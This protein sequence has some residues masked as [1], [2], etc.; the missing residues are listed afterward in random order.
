MASGVLV[1]EGGRL[2]FLPE[3]SVLEEG[4]PRKVSAL[5]TVLR[6]RHS[7]PGLSSPRIEYY[8]T[9]QPAAHLSLINHVEKQQHKIV[10]TKTI[11]KPTT[12][13]KEVPVL[14]NIPKIPNVSNITPNTIDTTIPNSIHTSIPNIISS[15]A[16]NPIPIY[17]NLPGQFYDP[18]FLAFYRNALDKYIEKQQHQQHKHKQGT[19]NLLKV[20]EALRKPNEP[21]YILPSPR[22]VQPPTFPRLSHLLPQNRAP[23]LV[24]IVIPRH[25]ENYVRFYDKKKLEPRSGEDKETETSTETLPTTT[26]YSVKQSSTTVSSSKKSR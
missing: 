17:S 14:S 16:P 24:N 2:E 20:N 7:G 18:Q 26:K 4:N 25:T 12:L 23:N 21:I 19:P 9:I 11:Q 15:N 1:R 5:W 10:F 13:Y 6:V 3:A 8:F 22:L